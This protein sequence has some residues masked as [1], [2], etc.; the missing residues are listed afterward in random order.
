M[1]ATLVKYI[2]S[3]FIAFI[4]VQS[5]FFKFSGSHETQYIFS[6]LGTWSGLAWFGQY[7]AY[8]IGTFELIASILLFTRLHGLAALLSMGIMTGAIFFHLFTPLGVPMPMFDSAGQVIGDDGGQLFILACVVWLSSGFLVIRDTRSTD[9]IL[10]KIL[11][12]NR[13]AL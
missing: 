1:K 13:A 8:L 10:T 7:G 12:I 11:P 9:G 5:L 3:L 6:T 2:P 4:F